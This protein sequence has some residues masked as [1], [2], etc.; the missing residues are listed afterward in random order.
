[1]GRSRRTFALHVYL[2]SRRV[3][4]LN[5]ATSGAVDFIYS[6]DW[7]EWEH[8]F[9]ISLSLPL[10]P[11]RYLGEVVIAV[12]DNLLPDNAQVRRRLAERARA[13]STDAFSLLAAI[14]R[15][16]VGAL[17]FLPEGMEPGT[18]GSVDAEPVSSGEI[19]ALLRNLEAAPLGVDIARDFRI[20][21]AGAQEKTAL[22]LREGIW[23][24]PIGSTPTTHILKPKLGH[25]AGQDLSNSVENEF[26]C[27]R[28][29]A[30]LGMPVARS[31]IID[32]EDQRV[33]VVERFDRRWTVDGRLLRLPQEDLCQ[34]L[35]YPPALRY[36]S[37]GGPGIEMA[38]GL[39]KGADD[40][41]EDRRRFLKAQ[42]IYWLLGATDGHAKNFSIF[43]GPGPGFRLAP[44]YDVMST[45]PLVDAGTLRRRDMKM[46]MAI[47]TNRHYAV[48]EIQLRHFE[49]T[50]ASAGFHATVVAQLAEELALELP[51]SLDF[52]A[53]EQSDAIAVAV[54]ESI[55]SGA[56]RR[57]N[58]FTRRNERE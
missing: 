38:M 19:A 12:F 51:R 54:L 7:L 58:R 34:A 5:R 32:F 26:L 33:L 46:S 10:R 14:G 45:Q 49:Q 40:P 6:A 39:L 18:A 1:M 28:L 24:R 3:G 42:M 31:E 43:L 41:L 56:M 27:G 44:L 8:A 23:Q 48:D 35:G 13:G 55:A 57:L 52:V 9:A 21:L 4:T 20:S 22:L 11:E 2:N 37:D 29:L 50:A 47:G 16:C 36:Q 15:D 25:R 30:V 17:Q 53:N